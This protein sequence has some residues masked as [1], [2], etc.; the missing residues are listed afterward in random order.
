MY[1][2]DVRQQQG[3]LKERYRQHPEQARIADTVE[4]LPA[5]LRDP[6]RVRA[7]RTGPPAFEIAI[8]LHRA[9][10]GDGTLPCPGD[11]L[12]A[13]LVA[14]Q[15]LTVRMVAANMGI[16]LESVQV[17]VTS[18]ADLRGTLAIDRETKVGAQRLDI[19]THVRVRGGD[20]ERS[21]RLLA[22]AERYCS[23][24]DTLRNPPRISTRFTCDHVEVA[25]PA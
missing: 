21:R 3:P 5:D 22:A 10:G 9:A 20:P 6:T 8:G 18:H 17:K 25:E 2:T 7:G 24:L 12:A 4:S 15:E 14:C 11:V 13:A 1:V 16:E 23:T 19:E